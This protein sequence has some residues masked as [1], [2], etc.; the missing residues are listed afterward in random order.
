VHELGRDQPKTTKEMLDIATR[1]AFGEEAVVTPHFTET[2]IKSHK[3][4]LSPNARINQV[5]QVRIQ[6]QRQRLK[7]SNC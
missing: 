3:L 4:Q 6:I 7:I 1:R 5:T 2:L